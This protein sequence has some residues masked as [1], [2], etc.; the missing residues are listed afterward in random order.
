MVPIYF[1]PGTLKTK[2]A[3]SFKY[4]RVGGNPAYKKTA[5]FNLLT[6][7]MALRIYLIFFS[8]YMYTDT[9]HL[10]NLEVS[11][12]TSYHMFSTKP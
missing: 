4:S 1:K 10:I 2:I 12:T 7:N 8:P 11:F 6:L 3:W 9:I 5:L